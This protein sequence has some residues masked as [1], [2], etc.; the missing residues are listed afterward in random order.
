MGPL[1][2]SPLDGESHSFFW[3]R[4]KVDLSDIYTTAPTMSTVLKLVRAGSS[5]RRKSIIFMLGI[6]G[7][8]CAGRAISP[9][10]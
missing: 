9:R 4:G 2:Q 10:P 8:P 3:G 5:T 6:L 7:V 1:V